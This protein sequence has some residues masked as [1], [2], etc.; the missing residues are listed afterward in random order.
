MAEGEDRRPDERIQDDASER[1]AAELR[2]D[3]TQIQVTVTDGEVTLAGT[4]DGPETRRRAEDIAG[5]VAG[6]RSVIN[7]L[8]VSQPGGTGVV[9]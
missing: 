7:N 4:V 8:R 3:A 2:S 5:S 9:G 1:L 6:V